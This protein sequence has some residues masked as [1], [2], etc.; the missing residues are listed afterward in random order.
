MR[1][2]DVRSLVACLALLCAVGCVDELPLALPQGQAI[3]VVI[4]GKGANERL[5]QPASEGYQ[6]LQSWV[7]QN[8]RGWSQLYA[9]PPAAGVLVTAGS[10]SL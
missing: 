6:Q 7:A 4:L 9:T 8:R 1:S 10:I 5:L 3:H 2:S